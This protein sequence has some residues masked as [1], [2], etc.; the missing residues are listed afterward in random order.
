[1]HPYEFSEK[2]NENFDKFFIQN[3]INE[4]QNIDT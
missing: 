4:I 1:M 2:N 3:S